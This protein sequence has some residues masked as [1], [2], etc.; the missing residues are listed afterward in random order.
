MPNPPASLRRPDFRVTVDT[1]EDFEV[2]ER[3]IRRFPEGAPRPLED[4][5]DMEAADRKAASMSGLKI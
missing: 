5:F 4:Y 1:P 2:M 3:I